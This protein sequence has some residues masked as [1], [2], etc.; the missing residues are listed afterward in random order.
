MLKAKQKTVSILLACLTMLAAL[1]FGLVS[2]FNT[3]TTTAS[4]ATATET[5]A[6]AGTTGT[7]SSDNNS[8]S[9]SQGIITFTN[10][11][12]S[13]AI[14]TDD[15]DHYRA[16]A[17]S[18]I[19]IS[20]S[21]GATITKVVITLKSTSS[22]YNG[23]T[24][25]GNI[26]SSLSGTSLTITPKTSTNTVSFNPSKQFRITAAQVT[27]EEGTACTHEE[28]ED[29]TFDSTTN[30]HYKTCTK[31]NE[32]MDGT[33]AACSE[34]T[35][36]DYT[37]EN[38]EHTRTATCTVCG[39]AQTESG[40]CEVVASDYVREGN[41]HSQTGTCQICG[42][43]TTVWEDCTLTY[44][45]VSNNN[46]THNTTSTCSVCQKD[47]T[48]EVPCSFDE[49]VLN[50]T[51]LTYT[52]EYCGYSYAEEATI[53]TVSYVV[54]NGIEEIEEVTVAEN[55][56]T[57]LPKAG[58]VEGY[59][60]VGWVE[61]E[62][63]EK[64]EITPTFFAAGEEYTV[65]EDVTLYA[66]YSYAEGTGAWTKVTNA[67]T[68]AVGKEIVI[69]ASTSD[70]ALGADKGNNRNAA[71][72]TKSGDTVTLNSDVQIITL[73]TG[74]VADT[75]A[76]NVGNGYLYAASSSSNYLKTK[77]TLDA[78]G[79]W[80]ISITS[81]GIA[82]IKAQGSNS[83]NWL[84]KNSTSALFACY[85]SGQADVSIYM[86]DSATYY[87]TTF[88]ACTHDNVSE[89]VEDA[90]CLES[91]SRTVTCLDC[92]SIIEAEVI[93]ALGHNFI[94]DVCEHCGNVD[95]A[96]IIYDG[97]YYLSLNGKYAGEKDGNYYKL[98]D[99]TPSETIDP[100]YVF[101][102]VKN[103][104]TYDMLYLNGG[105]KVTV[106][107]ETQADYTLKITNEEG[108]ILSH[109]TTYTAYQRMGFYAAS[110]SYPSAITLTEVELANIDSASVTVGDS[111]TVNYKVSMPAVYADAVMHFTLDG[112]TKEVSGT[113]VG[114]QYVF[115]LPVPPQAMADNIV[116]ELYFGE[117]IIASK[118]TYSIQEYAQN[119]LNDAGSSAELK[120]LV[121]DMLYYGA[122]AQIYKDHNTGN[123]ATAGVANLWAATDEAPAETSKSN[124][125]NTEI[126]E[127]PAYIASAGVYFDDVNQLYI[128]LNTIEN[129]KVYVTI[130]GV[131][132]E[133]NLTGT[134]YYTDGISATGFATE[135]I[136]E[137]YYG[138]TP[139]LMQTLTYSVDAYVYAKKDHAEI[140]ELALALYRYGKS[141]AA[142][143]A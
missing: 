124:V 107:I 82:T 98:L 62:L 49:G 133:A 77:T 108:K 52:C 83:R 112:N 32:E 79:S 85:S 134:T 64:T 88:N 13:T 125:Y 47:E 126:T 39:G 104:D 61:A 7:L 93:P 11:K 27:Y 95:P 74:N 90:T 136:F 118:A 1:V 8:I 142:Y 114:T 143:N 17:N 14:R 122:A 89:V 42:D 4:A 135:Y 140:G 22:S 105:S 43:E 103:G 51:I 9:W 30:E 132:T 97:Y 75:F 119:K 25:T 131:K 6:L 68:L 58:T 100:N 116:A 65:T 54:P 110:S 66:L 137:V 34:F 121:S 91:G 50:G 130:D 59:S 94:N 20:A 21:E 67:S 29:W 46:K 48:E 18:E 33:R 111:L 78:D 70:H 128:K 44:E 28:S 56:S 53:Y 76:F 71:S 55:F 38:G 81:A 127:Y 92:E 109:N 99:F 63:D 36:G 86:K 5:L 31:C 138:E 73:E 26:T 12:G 35:Y 141:A 80:A 19:R 3:P 106:M 45:N 72:I 15:S 57:K 16:Y 101:Y 2:F 129:V 40:D 120:R 115:S 24:F 10:V 87:V 102:F 139:T 69:V 123:L 96:S 41:K 113:L 60:F 84:R 37:T 117:T 23:G